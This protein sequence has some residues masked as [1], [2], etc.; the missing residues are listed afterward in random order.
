LSK[1]ICATQIICYNFKDKLGHLEDQTCYLNLWGITMSNKDVPN[2]HDALLF[3]VDLLR[4]ASPSLYSSYGYDIYIPHVIREYLRASGI[5]DELQLANTRLQ[6]RLSVPFYSAAWEL[7]RRGIIRPGVHTLWEQ[8]TLDGSAGNGYAVTPFG[9]QWLKEANHDTFVPTEPERFAGMLKPFRERFGGGFHLR[10]QEAV[11]CYSAHAYLACCAMC[12]AGAESILLACAVAKVGDE[13][14]VLKLYAGSQGRGRVE[15][16]LL[17]QADDSI[18]Q[19]FL[20]LTV[21]IKYW[22]DEAFRSKST[23]KRSAA[24]SLGT[25]L[26]LIVMP[27]RFNSC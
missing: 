2:D 18:R 19:Q 21:L 11:R 10:A 5:T 23:I 12:G 24:W 25:S 16:R 17:G 3:I 15:K 14:E 26:S 9:R 8:A 4:N 22:R 20:G 13:S 6:G 7:C 27:Q 1:E